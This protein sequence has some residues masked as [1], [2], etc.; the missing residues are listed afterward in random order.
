MRFQRIFNEALKQENKMVSLRNAV[1]TL[2][3]EGI[4]KQTLISELTQYYV[5]TDIEADKDVAADILD[6]LYGYCSPHMRI[7]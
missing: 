1:V 2:R 5:E 4:D 3:S 7:D 6:F